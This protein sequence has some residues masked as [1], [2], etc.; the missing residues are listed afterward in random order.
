MFC[1]GA[2]VRRYA[3]VHG[4]CCPSARETTMGT[5]KELYDGKMC[6]RTYVR[7]CMCAC[8]VLQNIPCHR[9][10]HGAM[11]ITITYAECCH[12]IRKSIFA[13]VI[14]CHFFLKYRDHDHVVA[15]LCLLLL[16]R[17]LPRSRWLPRSM[18][19]VPVVCR[20]V[21]RKRFARNGRGSVAMLP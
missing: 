6:I 4:F 3:R 1:I 14:F 8:I 9:F 18:Q 13:Q 11:E 15:I 19:T 20:L 5:I 7:A 17:S 21:E 12:H 2:Y 16:G 10:N